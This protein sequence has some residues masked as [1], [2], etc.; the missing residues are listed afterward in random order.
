VKVFWCFFKKE[1]LP[2]LLFH[3]S[4]LTHAAVFIISHPSI[5]A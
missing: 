5:S 4:F 2:L 1:P 3:V